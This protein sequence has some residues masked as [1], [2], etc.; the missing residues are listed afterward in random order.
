MP[1]MMP[2]SARR[3]T[4]AGADADMVDVIIGSSFAMVLLNL[5][6]NFLTG[7][8]GSRRKG[9]S[10]RV[11]APAPQREHSTTHT[12]RGSGPGPPLLSFI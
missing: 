2:C 9:E 10:I 1:D 3:T 8:A 6:Y 11:A 5:C 7:A 12:K 4:A